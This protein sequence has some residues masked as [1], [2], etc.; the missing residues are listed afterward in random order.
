[1]IKNNSISFNITS[2]HTYSEHSSIIFSI[3]L[4]ESLLNMQAIL[5]SSPEKL[6]APSISL[7]FTHPTVTSEFSY[8]E[9][10]I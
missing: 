10:N 2:K 1:M 6:Q 5:F 7:N 8:F 9:K 3:L 4:E